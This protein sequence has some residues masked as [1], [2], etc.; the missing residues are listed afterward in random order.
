MQYS[1]AT[2]DYL[3]LICAPPPPQLTE[4]LKVYPDT[5]NAY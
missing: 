5:S 1:K 4:R 3:A 2:C